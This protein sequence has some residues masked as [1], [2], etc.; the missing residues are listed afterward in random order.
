MFR[1]LFLNFIE[2]HYK[3]AI[4]GY[5]KFNKLLFKNCNCQLWSL[6]PFFTEYFDIL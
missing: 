5:K 6:N 3:F 1:I 2:L 4:N